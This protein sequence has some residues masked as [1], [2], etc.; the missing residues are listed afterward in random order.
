MA[1]F[2]RAATNAGAA[3]V[4][5]LLDVE[6]DTAVARFDGRADAVHTRAVRELYDA[7]ARRLGAVTYGTDWAL[8]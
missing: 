1:K 2:E 5:V 8:L 4:H 6:P 7:L 3:L